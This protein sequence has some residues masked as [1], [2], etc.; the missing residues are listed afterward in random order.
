MTAIATSSETLRTSPA[1]VH[2]DPAEGEARVLALDR[3]I[4]RL[5]HVAIVS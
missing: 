4:G 1:H 3:A 5:C 2:R